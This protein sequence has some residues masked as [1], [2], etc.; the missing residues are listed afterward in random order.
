MVEEVYMQSKQD[1]K[2]EDMVNSRIDSVLDKRE[3]KWRRITCKTS[4]VVAGGILATI[5]QW[6]M[7]NSQRAF[8]A[9]HVLIYGD[10][11]K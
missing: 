7:E 3:L 8:A 10:M 1:E 2:I 11:P 6:I 9:M 4:M 5:G